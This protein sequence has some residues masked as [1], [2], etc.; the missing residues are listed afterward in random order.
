MVR[1]SS[2]YPSILGSHRHDAMGMFADG[3]WSL[4]AGLK[5][6]VPLQ[7]FRAYKPF[8]PPWLKSWRGSRTL[9]HQRG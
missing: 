3:V 8:R 7:H 4:V 6:A 2:I 1:H 9:E 5:V